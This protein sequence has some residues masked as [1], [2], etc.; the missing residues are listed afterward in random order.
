MQIMDPIVE[1]LPICKTG[2][3][4]NE[5]RVNVIEITLSQFNNYDTPNIAPQNQISAAN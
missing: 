5:L 4:I 3:A 1:T 2:N